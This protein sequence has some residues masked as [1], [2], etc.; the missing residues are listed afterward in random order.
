M[1]QISYFEEGHRLYLEQNYPAAVD[2]FKKG[3]AKR[4][5]CQKVEL[6]GEEVLLIDKNIG[7]EGLWRSILL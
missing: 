3:V 5:L 2:Y 4:F 7:K 6:G 1:K